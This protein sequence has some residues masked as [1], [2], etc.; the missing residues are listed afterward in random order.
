MKKKIAVVW[1]YFAK[2]LGD[3]LMLK[4]FLNATKNKY[5]KVYI[6]SYKEYQDYYSEL[7]VVVVSTNSFFYRA[8]NKVFSVL[9]KPQLYYRYSITRNAD[10][11]MLGGS[12][13]AEYDNYSINQNQFVNLS[14]AVDK[15]SASYV[16]GSNFGP[17]ENSEFLHNY[18]SL[19]GRCKD[20]C[21]RDKQSYSFF[22]NHDNVRYAPD[23]ILSGLWDDKKREE[24]SNS[25]IISVINLDRRKD[26]KFAKKDYETMMAAIAKTHLKCGERVLL[27]AFC[28]FEGDF[29]ACVRIRN[30]C[31]QD[32]VDIIVYDDWDFLN[33]F[34]N[35]KK[36]YGTRFH[37]VILSM[38]YNIP[39][40]PFIYNQ[41]TYDALASYRTSFDCVDLRKLSDYSLK[42]ITENYGIRDV[43]F[44]LKELA[45]KQFD[46]VMDVV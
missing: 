18:F 35:A 36:I 6:N 21:F 34:S 40:V 39:C 7:G 27:A 42:E 20:V 13:F 33:L 4:A 12:L 32:N 14:Y 22:S 11:V 31:G 45:K 3:D 19:F 29:E 43:N 2:N 30:L 26:L 44:Q 37:S 10:F 5:T 38:Y 46:E 23:I 24:R 28:E 41:K 1:G 15:S 8:I 16:I 17:Y 9:R 25:V